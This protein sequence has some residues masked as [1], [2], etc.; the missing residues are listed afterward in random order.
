M[1]KKIL[2]ISAVV[3]PLTVFMLLMLL[4]S[5]KIR[6]ETSAQ[7]LKN[8]PK[9]LID[10]GHGGQDGGAVCNGVLEKDINLLIS[11]DS[12]DLIRLMGFDT[13]LTRDDDSFVS[14]SG[15]NVK[16]RKLN[17][18]KAR[19]KMYN[20]DESNVI[21]SIHQNKFSDSKAHGSQVFYSPNNEL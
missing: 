1:L 5:S 4:S 19:S 15:S 21:I 17:D 12:A 16:E 11:T 18:M 20:A 9:I 7:P 10:P 2:C 13:A 6:L 3:L 8:M 14:D